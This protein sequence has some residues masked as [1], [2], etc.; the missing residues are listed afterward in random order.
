MR[1]LLQIKDPQEFSSGLW[2]DRPKNQTALWKDGKN[3]TFRDGKI[4]SRGSIGTLG[5]LPYPI[6]E[7]GQAFVNGVRRIYL[8]TFNAVYVQN[9]PDLT[10]T[11]IFGTSPPG[12]TWVFQPFGSW[13][14]ATNG[15]NKPKIWKNTGMMADWPTFPVAKARTIG[16]LE[17]F[18]VLF[19]GQ[20]AYWPAFNNIEDFVPGP[21]KRAGEFFIRDLDGDVMACAPLRNTLVYYTQNMWGFMRF[22][23]GELA[24]SFEEGGTGI[25]AVSPYAVAYTNNFHFGISRKGIWQSDGSSFQYIAP[26]KINDWVLSNVDFEDFS[27]FVVYANERENM[28]EFFFMCKDGTRRGVGYDYQGPTQG[29]WTIFEETLTAASTQGAFEYP[30][31]GYFDGKYGFRDQED[32]EGSA[33]TL[34]TFPLDAGS[35]DR[36]K[37]WQNLQLTS[38]FPGAY[39]QA[40]V[41]FSDNYNDEPDW[42]AWQDTDGTDLWFDRESVFITIQLR[43]ASPALGDVRL[44][45][46]GIEVFGVGTGRKR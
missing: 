9:E 43:R 4:F 18:P 1:P 20:V 29:T 41:G 38:I 23:G 30:I 24:M 19:E 12:C 32:L 11:S 36:K 17:V 33:W 8:G 35:L 40:R 27:S 15:V 44:G 46:S 16:K 39:M 10:A 25:G 34:N 14:L 42:L 37:R 5:D 21:G 6:Q 2:P 3:I 31:V 26:P 45:L 13:L 7:I 28:I 22:V